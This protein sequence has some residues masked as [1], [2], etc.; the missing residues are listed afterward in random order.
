MATRG[1]Y[2]FA[3]PNEFLEIINGIIT[4]LNLHAVLAEGKK[5]AIVQELPLPLLLSV[6]NKQVCWDF[7]L[8]DK[9]V[10]EGIPVS[11]VNLPMEGWIQVVSPKEKDA[12]LWKGYIAIKTEWYVENVKYENKDSL[13][14]FNKLKRKFKKHLKYPMIGYDAVSGVSRSYKIGY[15]GG[16]EQ[17]QKE[18][19][20]LVSS[21]DDAICSTRYA[22][23]KNYI[24]VDPDLPIKRAEYRQKRAAERSSM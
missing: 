5:D 16:V 9:A 15:T 23:D 21:G 10:K 7:F 13:V 20:L 24:K 14:L 22:I 2:F 1:L 12:M 6:I 4:S 3:K 17:F 8:T 11:E 18:G 19:G